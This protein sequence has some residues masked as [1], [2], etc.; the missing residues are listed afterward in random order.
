MFRMSPQNKKFFWGLILI[1]AA[2]TIVINLDVIVPWLMPDVPYQEIETH[3][4]EYHR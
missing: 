2:L 4:A 1:L 3:L